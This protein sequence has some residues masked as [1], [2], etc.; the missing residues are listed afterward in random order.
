MPPTMRDMFMSTYSRGVSVD[1][2]AQALITRM[3]NAG[4][5]PTSARQNAINTCITSLRVNSLFDTQFD[6]LV[7]TRGTGLVST[8]MNWIKNAN[9]ALDVS[10][11][12]YYLTYTQDVG[13]H[14]DGNYNDYIDTQYNPSV[15]ASLYT[16]NNACFGFKVSG[17]MSGNLSF[18]G[19]L[20][21]ST[22]TCL[23][24][25]GLYSRINSTNYGGA[26]YIGYNCISRNNDAANQIMLN[27]STQTSYASNS[28]TP[29]N[30][31]LYMF[32]MNYSPPYQWDSTEILEAYW[33]GKGMTQAQFLTF[34]TIMNTYFASF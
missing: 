24:T 10:I 9:N 3:T 29:P 30:G 8:K 11:G 14:S 18:A 7:V 21:G 25:N 26:Y 5:T 13:Y 15:D 12:N 28:L 19:T 4:E 33:M 31:N 23:S 32:K 34:Q 20:I 1:S 17:S 6:V 2:D 16:Q 22:G 27:N